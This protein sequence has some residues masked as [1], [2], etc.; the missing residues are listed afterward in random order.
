MTATLKHP[1]ILA[2]VLTTVV[3]TSSLH[4]S[5]NVAR[6]CR[7]TA[8]SSYGSG[9]PANAVDGD[10]A[11]QWN[12]GHHPPAWIE[13]DLGASYSVDR[14]TLIVEQTPDGP[15]VHE[16]SFG[17]ENREFTRVETLSGQTVDGQTLSFAPNSRSGV[18][19]VRIETTSSPSWVAWNEIEVWAT[20][21]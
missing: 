21:Q 12:A 13:L 2:A 14:V 9:L 4:A 5:S 6:G 1:L 18:R 17:N 11:T 16:V 3:V 20:R 8:S 15:T 10:P 19:Y 7:V